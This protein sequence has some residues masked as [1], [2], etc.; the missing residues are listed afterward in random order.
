MSGYDKTFKVKD[1]NKQNELISLCIN[2]QKL[3]EKYKT[4]WTKIK[5]LKNIKLNALP[6]SDDRYLKAKI[7]NLWR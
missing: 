7:R 6:V 3:L 2:D 1:A 5:D 4:F